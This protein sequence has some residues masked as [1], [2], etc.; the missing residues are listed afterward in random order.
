ML[1]LARFFGNPNRL[2]AGAAEDFRNGKPARALKRAD[3]AI[4]LL[5]RRVARAG[6]G[7]MTKALLSDAW[8]LKGRWALQTGETQQAFRCFF[9]C[10]DR[11]ARDATSLAFVASEGCNLKDVPAQLYPL[12]VEYVASREVRQIAPDHPKIAARI[13]RLLRPDLARPDTIEAVERWNAALAEKAEDCAWCQYHLGIIAV[14]RGDWNRAAAPLRR[15][16]GLDPRGESARNLFALAVL[17]VAPPQDALAILNEGDGGSRGTLLMRAHL[18]QLCGD[19]ATA[20]KCYRD[21][22]AAKPLRSED[23]LAFAEILVRLDRLD[24]A[25][26]VIGRVPGKLSPGGRIVKALALSG[27]GP[28]EEVRRP[29]ADLAKQA[30]AA[31][32]D[33]HAARTERV[34]SSQA[35]AA[36]LAV[37]AQHLDHPDAL[38]ALGEI[39][40]ADRGRL[41]HLTA[42]ACHAARKDWSGAAAEWSTLC[43]VT[44]VDLGTAEN[45]SDR[46]VPIIKKGTAY[47]LS[48][49]RTCIFYPALPRPEV[50]RIPIY[51]GDHHQAALN[52]HQCDL[53]IAVPAGS[54]LSRGVEVSFDFDRNRVMHAKANIFG[55]D[56]RLEITYARDRRH[57]RNVSAS[58]P[59]TPGK[60]VISDK[61]GEG[62]NDAFWEALEIVR[63]NSLVDWYNS[64]DL[65]SILKFCVWGGLGRATEVDRLCI[66]TLGRLV[67]AAAFGKL[68]EGELEEVEQTVN[69]ASPLLQLPDA[70]ELMGAIFAACGRDPQA[71][72]LLRETKRLDAALIGARSALRLDQPLV[73][74]EILGRF[75]DPDPRKARLLAVAAAKRR[76]WDGALASLG[77]DSENAELHAALA[78]LAGRPEEL[79]AV[80][81]NG[82]P[83]SY[84]KAV[85]LLRGGRRNE[86]RSELERIGATEPMRAD[87]DR[88]LGWI[89]LGEAAEALRASDLQKAQTDLVAAARYW[90]GADGATAMLPGGQEGLL[91][92]LVAA[93]HRPKLHEALVAESARHGFAD[94]RSCHRLAIFQLAEG[95]AKILDGAHEQAIGEWE[96]AIGYLAVALAS[97][98][99]ME[100]WRQDRAVAYNYPLGPEVDIDAGVRDFCAKLFESAAA[101]T[102]T[103]ITASQS[104]RQPAAEVAEALRMLSLALEAELQAAQLLAQRGGFAH[105]GRMLVFGPTMLA[106]SELAAEFSEHCL[107]LKFDDIL[108][109]PPD[110]LAATAED[111]QRFFSCLRV[112]ALLLRKGDIAGASKVFETAG[113]CCLPTSMLG[114]C[115]KGPLRGC[116]GRGEVFGI[117]NPAFAHEDGPEDLKHSAQNLQ[118]TLVLKLAD[119]EIRKEEPDL[120]RLKPLWKEAIALGDACGRSEEVRESISTLVRGR[121][122]QLLSDK[123]HDAAHALVGA[124]YAIVPEDELQT[125]L[126]RVANVL[127]VKLLNEKEDFTTAAELL[128]D[129]YRLNPHQLLVKQNLIVV[130]RRMADQAIG[131]DNDK[132]LALLREGFDIG[133][134]SLCEDGYNEEIADGVIQ[135]A[136]GYMYTLRKTA[137]DV[138]GQNTRQAAIHLRQ[139]V[140]FGV[141]CVR[142][143]YARNDE[144]PSLVANMVG[145]LA[146]VVAGVGIEIA[147]KSEKRSE[148][149]FATASRSQHE[150]ADAMDLLRAAHLL[151]PASPDITRN[152]IALL[153]EQGYNALKLL[154]PDSSSS[155]ATEALRQRG[156]ER[157]RNDLRSLG[158][159]LCAA[160]L[161]EAQAIGRNWLS[162]HDDRDIRT[163]VNRVSEDLRRVAGLRARAPASSHLPAGMTGHQLSQPPSRGERSIERGLALLENLI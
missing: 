4:R 111:I 44:A 12:L 76:E 139:A 22:D 100:A 135:T 91:S 82:G 99:Y 142:D 59:P 42:G 128:R 11:V 141:E 29:L 37:V 28:V 84:F 38:A 102:R 154:Q 116:P 156:A 92:I 78:F 136:L 52:A 98:S 72:E 25:R 93:N 122:P 55:N 75:K 61:I 13:R 132:C 89:M 26:K 43:H 50:I 23:L 109:D 90:P 30:T 119:R 5:Q 64:G 151:D 101:R 62:P 58:E 162:F 124:A 113:W 57:S 53:E 8:F 17:H 66:L 6:A 149:E 146:I 126:V 15:A 118:L 155:Y 140:K 88:L 86:A 115:V 69:R 81:T 160:L 65:A 19:L 10:P 7:A 105:E 96:R 79:A 129:A 40:P 117:C 45:E 32:A 158:L 123:R 73:A 157:W 94:P 125:E 148:P 127:A 9:A 147:N 106:H 51:E 143:G 21:A 63:L 95:R 71:V 134:R 18:E 131:K 108:A 24:E 34:V 74:N 112:P 110:A 16:V 3:R 104:D 87:A 150:D 85:V 159:A 107:E 103:E 97:R 133:A 56:G 60:L 1:L 33:D 39:P 144:I 46:F 153:Q 137:I 35:T 31:K 48:E 67:R 49:P 68:H 54:D 41:Y 138:A 14:A 36:L 83:G 20:A 114:R 120:E 145:E 80:P 163:L 27:K 161:E 2:L 47:P 70:T 152:L 130:L 121:I 77:P